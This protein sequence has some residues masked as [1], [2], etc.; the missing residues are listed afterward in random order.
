MGQEDMI[1]RCLHCGTKNRIPKERMGNRPLCGHCRSHLDDMIIRCLA[2]GKKNRMPEN[3]LGNRPLCGDCGAPLVVGATQFYP[4]D[5]SDGTF[6]KEVLT[7]EGAVLVDCWAPWCGPCRLLAPILDDL[8]SQ[9]AG[10]VKIAKLN[11]DE[12]PLTASQYSIRSIPTMLLF[13]EGILINSLVGVQTKEEI[14]RNLLAIM[15]TN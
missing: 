10:G 7:Y 14:E 2:C 12:N 3:R 15:K 11:V 8:A 4:Q 6:S 13:K 1:I 5:V 9:Y